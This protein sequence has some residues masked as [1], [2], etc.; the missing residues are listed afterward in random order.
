MNNQEITPSRWYYGLAILVVMGGG[1]LFGVILW[2]NL[3]GLA[4]ALTQVVVPGKREVALREAGEYTIFYERESVVGNKVYS[5]GENISGL[6]CALT[7][8]TSGS[9]VRLSRSTMSSTYSVGGRSGVSVW[10]F[11]VEQPG[12]LEIACT[13]EGKEGP[14]VVLA[15][16]KDFTGKLVATIFGAI[17]VLFLSVIAGIAIAVVTLLKRIKAEK[18]L[19]GSTASG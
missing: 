9:P 8:K 17:G 15:V 13:Y 4:D 2:K 19:R 11:K 10:E 5:T 3:S 12:A 6:A 16:G 7:S 1:A 14:E 18:A